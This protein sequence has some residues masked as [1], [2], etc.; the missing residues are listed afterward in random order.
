MCSIRQD[1]MR[2]KGSIDQTSISKHCL[3]QKIRSYKWIVDDML[4]LQENAKIRGV[5]SERG[6]QP[7]LI[8]YITSHTSSG[9]T[10]DKGWEKS[11]PRYGLIKSYYLCRNRKSARRLCL[12][13]D[14]LR[15]R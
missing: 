13:R 12:L 5:G 8:H 7:E 9:P 2:G 15:R 4:A 10:G 14:P 1:A 11:S 3:L 6:A